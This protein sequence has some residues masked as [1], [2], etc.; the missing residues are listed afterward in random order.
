MSRGLAALALSVSCP[1]SNSTAATFN[2]NWYCYTQFPTSAPS[3]SYVLNNVCGSWISGGTLLKFVHTAE[4]G[5]LSFRNGAASYFGAY[6]PAGTP[7][8]TTAYRYIDGT[9]IP[10]QYLSWY[11]GRPVGNQLVYV[12]NTFQFED[13]SQARMKRLLCR[14]P[15][16]APLG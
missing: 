10:S 11:P 1:F 12:D 5:Y 14:N 9:A 15:A 6:L 2:G 8:S 16:P 13:F 3:A 7:A 4:P